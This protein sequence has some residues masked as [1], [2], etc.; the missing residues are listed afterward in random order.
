MERRDRDASILDRSVIVADRLSKAFGKRTVLSEIDLDIAEGEV[1]GYLGPNGA[2][3]TT[4]T[5][6]LLGLLRPSAGTARVG[7]YDLGRSPDARRRIG[8]LLE[9]NGLYDR[10]SAIDNLSYYAELYEVPQP[11]RR[12]DEMLA[13]AGLSDRAAG[14]RSE[15]SPRACD[16][17]SVSLAPSSIGRRCCFSTNRPPASIRKRRSWSAI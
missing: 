13:L 5:R 3:K 11:K 10:L 16:A 1:F 14:T 7:G 6:L 9:T 17:A 8:V 4:T 12:I 15:R 2:G